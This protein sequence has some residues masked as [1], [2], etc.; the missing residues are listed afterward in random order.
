MLLLIAFVSDFCYLPVLQIVLLE[1]CFD[2]E[3]FYSCMLEIVS[4]KMYTIFVSN[5]DIT[6]NGRAP[7]IPRFQ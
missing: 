1:N 7:S 5:Y 4:W 3:K 2:S 6:E